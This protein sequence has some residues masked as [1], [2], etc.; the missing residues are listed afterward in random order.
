MN[1]SYSKKRIT[2]N[3]DEKLLLKV[4]KIKAYPKWRGNRSKV[5]E[6]AIEKYLETNS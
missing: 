5:I 2:I 1:G 6:S 3:I 4:D